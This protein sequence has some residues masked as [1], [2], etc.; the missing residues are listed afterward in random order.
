MTGRK[1][2]QV[3]PWKDYFNII[4]VGIT[5]RGG[6]GVVFQTDFYARKAEFT[7]YGA[8]TFGKK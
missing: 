5:G 6:G 4:H 8:K 3:N 7:V 1:R 2:T